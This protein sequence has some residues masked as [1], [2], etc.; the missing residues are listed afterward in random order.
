MAVYL[1]EQSQQILCR[2]KDADKTVQSF[3]SQVVPVAIQCALLYLAFTR[4]LACIS[5]E[6]VYMG[7]P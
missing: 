2:F 6:A 7:G 5:A 3:P 1:V 4:N